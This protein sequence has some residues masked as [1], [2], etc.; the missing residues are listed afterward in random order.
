MNKIKKIRFILFLLTIFCFSIGC[1]PVFDWREYHHDDGHWTALFP[2]KPFVKERKLDIDVANINVKIKMQQYSSKVKEMNFVVNNIVVSNKKINLN[3]LKN[4]LN[5][6]LENN[7][8]IIT[9]K[10]IDD[11]LVFYL[12]GF[13]NSK[14][15]NEKILIYVYTTL[16]PNSIVR[17][18]VFSEN[19]FFS[20]EE[21]MLFIRSIKTN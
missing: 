12:G 9:K 7:L 20:E 21:A 1:S 6:R 13:L 5:E 11:N 4:K 15:Q 16:S 3:T 19:K 8:N 10:F 2:S 14:N 17:G 18:V